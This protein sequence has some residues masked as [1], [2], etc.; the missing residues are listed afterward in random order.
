M[1]QS[2]ISV[3][4]FLVDNKTFCLEIEV[5]DHVI[6]ACAVSALPEVSPAVEGIINVRGRIMPVINMGVKCLGRS[7]PLLI[8]DKFIIIFVSNHYLAL[9]VTDTLEIFSLKSDAITDVDTVLPGLSVVRGI[10]KI[11]Q[12]LSLLY[13]PDKFF[14]TEMNVNSDLIEGALV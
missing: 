1:A 3:L 13:N 2:T 11:N 14:K 6:N 7:L 5:I 8:T 4:S 10:I 12:D 9:H